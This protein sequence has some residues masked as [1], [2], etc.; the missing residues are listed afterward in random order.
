MVNET[1]ERLIAYVSPRSRGGTSLFAG[2]AVIR[3]ETAAE[4]ISTETCI[5]GACE[6]LASRG[7]F[8]SRVGPISVRI[9]GP[10]ALFTDQLGVRFER[11]TQGQEAARLASQ[12]TPP[13]LTPT[14]ESALML[15]RYN[16]GAIEG[17]VFP[18]P[19]VLHE[20]S[21]SPPTPDYHHLKVPKDLVRLLN[22]EPVH[23]SG[24]RGQGVRAAMI[25][26]G[27][28]WS[29]PYFQNRGYSL[30][31]SLPPGKRH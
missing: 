29:L 9:E 20:P 24:T 13:P 2:N 11:C 1:P 18:E 28:H 30:T 14:P 25:D 4:F 10:A 19:A 6:Q 8:V 26:S 3:Q 23:A 27:F 21:P 12:G 5:R 22:A 31:V 17:I 16:E 7:F 15:A